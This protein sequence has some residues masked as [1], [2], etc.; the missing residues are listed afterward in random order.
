M[1]LAM[2]VIH[3]ELT[4]WF[5]LF[6]QKKTLQCADIAYVFVQIDATSNVRFH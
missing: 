5:F 4:M 6:L 1:C 3:V 2:Y